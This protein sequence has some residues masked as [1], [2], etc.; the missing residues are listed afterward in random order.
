MGD[1]LI[2]KWYKTWNKTVLYN[3]CTNISQ[4]SGLSILIIQ[5]MTQIAI[6]LPP[7]RRNQFLDI[8]QIQIEIT[9][10]KI[11]CTVSKKIFGLCRRNLWNSSELSWEQTVKNLF[12]V[13]KVLRFSYTILW[14]FYW[15]LL[16][17]Q[18]SLLRHVKRKRNKK[19]IDSVALRCGNLSVKK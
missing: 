4:I 10:R 14:E 15:K 11:V 6:Q 2:E 16:I 18:T 1:S 3:L 13:V 7:K 12:L 9:R 8:S 5:D 17:F 19:I